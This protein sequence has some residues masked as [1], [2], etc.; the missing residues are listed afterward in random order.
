M[1]EIRSA[2]RVTVSGSF[3]Q[4]WE[5]V[6][7]SVAAFKTAGV[8]VLSP[9][10]T[11]RDDRQVEGFV[12]LKGEDGFPKDIELHHLN[13]IARSDALYVVSPGG[14][15]GPS[16]ALEIGYALALHVPVRCSERLKDV[17]HRDLVPVAS[18]EQVI[19]EFSEIVNRAE[20]PSSFS[21]KELQDYYGRIA[22]QLGFHKETP[23]EVLILLVEEVG[24]LA[25][26]MRQRMQVSVRNDDATIKTVRVELADCFIYL[27]HMANQTNIDLLQAFLEKVRAVVAKKWIFRNLTRPK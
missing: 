8:Q 12:Y 11:E 26:A 16:A 1:D 23:E 27:L 3:R 10:S 9:A 18:E 22:I 15:L 19:L 7:R 24:E 25:K 5:S 6:R 13:S 17:P 14:Y 2:I 4:H 20:P 21:L